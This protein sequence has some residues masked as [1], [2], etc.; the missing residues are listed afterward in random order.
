MSK[1]VGKMAGCYSPMGKTFILTDDD[2]NEFTG[3]VT[4]QKKVFDAG[5]NDIR[6]GK[7]AANSEGVVVGEKDIP[8]YR[9][10]AGME[11][12]APESSISIPLS[13]FSQYDY[14]VFQCMIALANLDDLDNSIETTMVSIKD[15]VYKVNSTE[16]LA[17]VSKNSN[18]KSIDLN[19]NNNS[20]NRYVVYYF[21]YREEE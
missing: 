19:I 6:A 5:L 3:V 13:Q 18:T 10:T 1:I 4:D 8:G 12:I 9:T 15:G 17:D 21:T 14:T 20:E 7:V 2:G 16:K 11:L